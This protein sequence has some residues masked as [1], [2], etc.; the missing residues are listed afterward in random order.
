LGCFEIGVIAIFVFNALSPYFAKN[1]I[2]P[3]IF[4]SQRDS[5]LKTENAI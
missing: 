1:A 4:G 2:N 5:A 3:A